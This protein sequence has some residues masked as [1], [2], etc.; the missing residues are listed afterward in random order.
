MARNKYIHPKPFE[1]D[2]LRWQK[3]KNIPRWVAVFLIVDLTLV[4]IITAAIGY[5]LISTRVKAYYA[6]A[7]GSSIRHAQNLGE[8][9]DSMNPFLFPDV[10][11]MPMMLNQ[12]TTRSSG[13]QT[14][15]AGSLDFYG[16]DFSNDNLRIIITIQPPDDRVNGGKPIVIPIFAARECEFGEKTACVTAYKPN[17]VGN[18]IF[19][20]V[21][22]GVGGE[23]QR[24]RHAIEGTGIDS[25]G[26]ALEQVQR[27]LSTL[28][29]AE[30]TI[31]QDDL[32]LG[33]FRLISTARV[34]AIGLENY[35]TYPVTEALHQASAYN[36][37]LVDLIRPRGPQL[38]I[39][40]CG[41]KMDGEPWAAEVTSTSAAI[42]LGVIRRTSN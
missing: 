23:A 21:H 16:V 37:H 13:V 22:S 39:E 29:G 40:T 14:F 35:I 25:A 9:A 6:D 31:T 2:P 28:N 36:P 1:I 24:L 4:A 5:V 17:E 10:L 15:G 33:G 38:V 19:L 12:S 34:P 7:A 20:S 8:L 30:V 3:R 41:W 18:V 32:V 42:Y 26:Y 11:H 27:N